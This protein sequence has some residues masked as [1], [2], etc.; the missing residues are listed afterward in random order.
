VAARPSVRLAAYACKL[1]TMTRRLEGK[2]AIVTGATSGMGRAIARLFAREGAAVVGNG[3][4]GLR[5]AQLVEEITADGGRAAFVPGDVAEPATSG[6]LVAECG[7]LF[8]RVDVAV[9]NAGVLGLGSVTDLTV[10]SWRR[11]LGVNLDAVFYLI[12]SAIP[13]MTAAGGGSIVVNGSIAAF[14]AF[15]N[16]AAYCASKGA[17]VALVR[18]VAIDV[19]PTIRVNALC[20]G[21]VDTPLLWDSAAGFPRPADA[22]AEAGRRTVLK[23]LGTP[24]DVAAAALFLASSDSGWITGTALTIDGGIMTGNQG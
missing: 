1:T 11:T 23:R 19:G 3:R 2:A 20:P 15:P 22:V 4:D 8:G 12:K 17:V 7:R 9:A 13:A 10:E 5:G 14:K 24:D 16:H 6:R 18:Q 21:P